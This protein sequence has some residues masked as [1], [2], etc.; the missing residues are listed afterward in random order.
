MCTYEPWVYRFPSWCIVLYRYGTEYKIVYRGHTTRLAECATRR[1]A[2]CAIRG[3]SHRSLVQ[4]IKTGGGRAV[5]RKLGIIYTVHAV[6]ILKP[7][8]KVGIITI[9]L[10]IMLLYLS[11]CNEGLPIDGI[12]YDLYY[13]EFSI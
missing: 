13:D 7:N 8:I 12:S 1:L 9:S 10:C 11:K 2:E 3:R 6:E 5:R 4:S